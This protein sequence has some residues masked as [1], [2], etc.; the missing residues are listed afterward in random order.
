MKRGTVAVIAVLVLGFSTGSARAQTA[1]QGT[2]VVQ[3][4]PVAGHVV[5]ASLP[6]ARYREPV[7]R[8]IV[9]ERV[10]MPRGHAHGWRRQHGYRAVTVYYDGRRYYT[11]RIVRPGIRAVIV[12]ERSGRYYFIDDDDRGERHRYDRRHED[13]DDR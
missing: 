9:V 2:V 11:R 7:R 3:S 10:R 13:R 8:V 5:V 12:Y 4:G 6:P 1:V